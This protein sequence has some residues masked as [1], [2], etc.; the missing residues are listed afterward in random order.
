MT[1]MMFCCCLLN[2]YLD[3][4]PLEKLAMYEATMSQ[5]QA[6]CVLSASSTSSYEEAA[7]RARIF[8]YAYTQEGLITGIRGGRFVL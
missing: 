8:W 7:A 2:D 3:A 1:C 4:Q 6:L 5:V